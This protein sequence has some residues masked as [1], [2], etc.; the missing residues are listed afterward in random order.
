MYGH[1]AEPFREHP[2]TQT[3]KTKNQMGIIHRMILVLKWDPP[4]LSPITHLIQNQ[5]RLFTSS[6]SF[7]SFSSS[8]SSSSFLLLL[9][10]LH[11]YHQYHQFSISTYPVVCQFWLRQK[12]NFPKKIFTQNVAPKIFQQ[13]FWTH[14]IYFWQQRLKSQRNLKF[15]KKNGWKC[16]PGLVE[17]FFSDFQPNFFEVRMLFCNFI[18]NPPSTENIAALLRLMSK[19]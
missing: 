2:G 8:S 16:S 9:F 7:S 19:Y 1:T 10:L 12:R 3:W 13:F 11:H 5:K 18:F 6:S 4:S 17:I 15:S 14:E